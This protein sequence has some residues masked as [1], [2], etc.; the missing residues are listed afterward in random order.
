[1]PPSASR[2]PAS[3][4]IS[5]RRSTVH[6]RGVFATRSIA[7]D[8]LICEYKGE[9][10]DWN[11]ALR[12]HPRDPSDPDH[13]FYFDLGDGTV[14]D[15]AVGGNSAR[16]INHSCAPN[17]EAEDQTG[18]IFIRAI[19]PI[20]AGEELSIDYALIVE[21]RHTRKLR[22]QYTCRCNASSCRGTMLAE[23][24]KQSNRTTAALTE[25]LANQHATT[26]AVVRIF[27]R[28][29]LDQ[30]IVSWRE[31]GRCCYSEQRWELAEASAAGTCALSSKTFAAGAKVF[32]PIGN[33][34]P[35]NCHARI[36]ESS[37]ND[38][39]AFLDSEI[40]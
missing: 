3:H 6:G 22:L 23:R 5:V 21:A 4:K 33:P 25:S 13:T 37:V 8:E 40:G 38:L 28:P 30:L 32:Q 29:S 16:W 20:T 34:T 19:R 18:R 7:I 35:A 15:G 1:M 36:A 9:R 2:C 10:I 24:R 27:E 12:R 39:A 17:C 26:Q 14:I 31:A 11:E